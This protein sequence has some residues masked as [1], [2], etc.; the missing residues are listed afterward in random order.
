MLDKTLDRNPFFQYHYKVY[1]KALMFFKTI[2]LAK[3]METKEFDFRRETVTV[4][5]VSINIIKQVMQ[6]H[7]E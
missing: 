3:A 4:V 5:K 1:I 2:M 7:I 6:I